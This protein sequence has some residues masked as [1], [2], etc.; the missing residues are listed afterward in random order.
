M[1]RA[2]ARIT[3]LG[4]CLLPMA[5]GGA[6]TAYGPA[7]DAGQDAEVPLEAGATDAGAD[8]ARCAAPPA[9]CSSIPHVR[10]VL[11]YSLDG[12]LTNQGTSAGHDGVASGPF[13]FVKG[14][15]GKALALPFGSSVTFPGTG[16]VLSAA[17]AL[18]FSVWV[19]VSEPSATQGRTY[20]GCRS[21]PDGFETYSGIGGGSF[22]TCAGYGGWPPPWGACA[23]VDPLCS[24]AQFSHFVLRWR[25]PGHAPEVAA[26]GGPW[27][28][29]NSQTL[30][31]G[32]YP[33]PAGFNLFEGATDLATG[34]GAGDGSGAAGT[35]EVAS[36]RVYDT[37]LADDVVWNVTGCPVP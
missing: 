22:T 32:P 7:G 24:L 33:V 19:R 11:A 34:I 23:T 3:L 4:A 5:C 30:D 9:D 26:D 12:I 16:A 35:F 10:P 1:L 17:P 6:A 20:L 14:I 21:E 13:S 29:L 25:G 27:A 28:T 8:A 36:I 31:G 18:T 37:A 2:A 15:S